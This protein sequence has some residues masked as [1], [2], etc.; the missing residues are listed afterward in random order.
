MAKKTEELS[1]VVA[2]VLRLA[3]VIRDYW[4]VELPRVH[5]DYP[6]VRPDDLEETPPPEEKQLRD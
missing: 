4:A 2:E 6:L 5:P 3:T 1:D